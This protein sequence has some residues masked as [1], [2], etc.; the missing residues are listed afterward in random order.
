MLELKK[1][2]LAPCDMPHD[3]R[4]RTSCCTFY[5]LSLALF[6]RPFGFLHCALASCGAVYCNRSCLWVCVCLC[7]WVCY[8]DNSKLRA[9]ILNKLG[10][11]VKAV[12]ICSWLNFGRPAPPGRGS[13]AWHFFGS[14]LLQPARSVCV[15][16][17]AFSF[18]HCALS[19]AAQCIVIGPVCGG[20]R[21]CVCGSVI[22]ITRN[23]VHRF[24]P[25]R[26]C[27]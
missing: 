24:S 21:V 18:L 16:L 4:M 19:L 3:M 6:A 8:H 23:C 25:N 11:W 20:R 10:F 1:R 7:L 2:C 17:S 5:L 13:A 9:S 22:T 27:G 14:P 26:V 15:S 12:T